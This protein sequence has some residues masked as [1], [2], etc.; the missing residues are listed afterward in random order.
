MFCLAEETGSLS[1]TKA[2]PQHS[3]QKFDSVNNGQC[4]SHAKLS[5]WGRPCL[6]CSCQGFMGVLW[7]HLLL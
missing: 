2:S 1:W 3:G 6:A 4:P 5:L 7:E